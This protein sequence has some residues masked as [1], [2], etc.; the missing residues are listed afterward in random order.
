MCV[1]GRR[2]EEER[3]P[4]P[5]QRGDRGSQEGELHPPGRG[6]VQA[7]ART[8]LPLNIDPYHFGVLNSLV[9]IVNRAGLITL[10]LPQ[11]RIFSS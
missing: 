9:E 1:H 11:F 10:R 2:G 4:V 5:V 3:D 7:G 6:A 8:T